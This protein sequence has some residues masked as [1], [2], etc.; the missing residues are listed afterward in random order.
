MPKTVENSSELVAADQLRSFVERIERLQDEID[1]LNADKS[2]VFKEAKGSGC[3]VAAIREV[4]SVRRKR[5]KDRA[6]Y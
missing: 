3:D 1:G 6:A 4:I 2:D 5:A